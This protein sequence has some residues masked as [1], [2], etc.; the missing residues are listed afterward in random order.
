VVFLQISMVEFQPME[1]IDTCGFAHIT[2]YKGAVFSLCPSSNK[3][4]GNL[5]SWRSRSMCF[6][7]SQSSRCGL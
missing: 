6:A 5:H 1:G 2:G 4:N 7:A 3:D